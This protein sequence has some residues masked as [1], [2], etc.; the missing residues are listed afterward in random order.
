MTRFSDGVI[1]LETVFFPQQS[2]TIDSDTHGEGG[3]VG[4]FQWRPSALRALCSLDTYSKSFPGHHVT[5]DASVRYEQGD[6]AHM[7]VPKAAA[8]TMNADNTF[9]VKIHI[10]H[11]KMRFFDTFPRLLFLK[12]NK[13]DDKFRVTLSR[14]GVCLHQ[15]IWDPGDNEIVAHREEARADMAQAPGKPMGAM[16][17]PVCIFGQLL[18]SAEIEEARGSLLGVGPGESRR[19]RR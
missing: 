18:A 6:E 17:R 14:A 13:M 16:G 15:E 8:A 3:Y 10:E 1:G 19:L 5:C 2:S 7:K 11:D 12:T 4:G 9:V